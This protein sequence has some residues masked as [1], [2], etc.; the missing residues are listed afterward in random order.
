MVERIT[1]MKRV[2]LLG[3]LMA[4]M[5]PAEHVPSGPAVGSVVPAFEVAD[6]NGKPQTLATLTGP[7]GL[8][9]VFFRSADW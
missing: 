5:A 4:A 8:L 7:K 3:V 2:T 9:L 1:S 6:L